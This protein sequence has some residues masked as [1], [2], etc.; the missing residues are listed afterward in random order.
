MNAKNIIR[1]SVPILGLAVL[2]ALGPAETFGQAE[3]GSAPPTPKGPHLKPRPASGALPIPLLPSEI[4]AQKV[5]DFDAAAA[6]MKPVSNDIDVTVDVVGLDIRAGSSEEKQLGEVAA[7]AAGKYYGVADAAKLAGVFAQVASGTPAPAGGGGGMVL[8]K[9]GLSPLALGAVALGILCLALAAGILIV[10]NR[11][12]GTGAG[13]PVTGKKIRARAEITLPDGRRM[14]YEIRGP[15]TRLGRAGD[16]AIVL[17]DDQVSSRHAE[18]LAGPGG[19]RI[20]DLDSTNGTYVRGERV[21]EAAL[22]AG[23][24]IMAGATRIGL[25]E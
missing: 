25:G 23:D 19:F 1:C 21:S 16:N 5:A 2:L 8:P 22:C 9:A 14:S 10:R 15:V 7:A 11:R 3:G 17:D 24:E 18:I 20:R 12:A 13:K 6:A 4:D